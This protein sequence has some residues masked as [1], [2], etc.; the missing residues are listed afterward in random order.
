MFAN[1]D[2]MNYMKHV[3]WYGK[4]VGKIDHCLLQVITYDKYM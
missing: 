4:K 3:M 2:C 1:S